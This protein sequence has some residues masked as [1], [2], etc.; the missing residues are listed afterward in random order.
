MPGQ[1]IEDRILPSKQ[2]LLFKGAPERDF[3]NP[4][5]LM[6]KLGLS[7]EEMAE[8]VALFVDSC[9]KDLEQMSAAL[10]AEDAKGVSECA[11]SIKG[12]SGNMRFERVYEIAKIIEEDARQR[13]LDNIQ[14]RIDQIRI[15]IEHIEEDLKTFSR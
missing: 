11:H 13:S 12:A 8:L 15:S 7:A 6:E 10:A 3:M 5:E 4:N 1:G 2:S 14:S 9:R